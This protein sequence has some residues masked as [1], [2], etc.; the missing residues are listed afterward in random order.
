MTA[1][2]NCLTHITASTQLPSLAMRPD[3]FFPLNL[4]TTEADEP[5]LKH[6]SST[7][8]FCEALLLEPLAHVKLTSEE[9]ECMTF[10]Q[11]HIH[12]AAGASIMYEKLKAKG[13]EIPRSTTPRMMT[14]DQWAN[15]S[16]CFNEWPF[17]PRTFENELE[18]ALDDTYNI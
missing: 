12:A 18:L 1:T 10:L 16:R 17:K 6:S 4:L 15:L 5:S 11:R 14:G 3:Q 2:A 9:F 13:Q 7:V 8:N